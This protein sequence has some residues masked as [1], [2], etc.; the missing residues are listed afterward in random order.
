[1]KAEPSDFQEISELLNLTSV[2]VDSE[3]ITP[4]RINQFF[5]KAINE[6]DEIVGVI[7]G[8]SENDTLH[9]TLI[10][11]H[12]DYKKQGIGTKLLEEA[13]R[14]YP[15]QHFKLTVNHSDQNIN[16]FLERSGYEKSSHQENCTVYQKNM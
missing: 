8:C 15:H 4:Q 11:V 1:M 13:E 7:G 5:L 16:G 10:A 2:Y 3:L 9:I 12:P 14:E 6:S